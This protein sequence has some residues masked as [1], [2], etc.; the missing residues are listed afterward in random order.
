MIVSPQNM[1]FTQDNI[2]MLL[3]GLPGTGKTTLACSAPDPLIVDIDN[4]VKRVKTEHRKDAIMV[5]TYEELIEDLA[6]PE[7]ANYKTIIIDTCGALIELMKAW[8]E[9]QPNGGKKSGGI[10]QAG[11]GIIKSEFSSLFRKLRQTHNCLLLFHSLKDKDQ[12]GNIIYDIQC[13]GATKQTV[14]Q[15]CDLG[16][17][18]QIINDTRFLCFTPTQTYSAKSTHGIKGMIKVPELTDGMPNDF[19]TSIFAMVKENI[20]KEAES[21]KT[22]KLEYEAAM[23]HGRELVS[24]ISDA[25]TAKE[26]AGMLKNVPEA[27]TSKAELQAMFK[28]KVAEIGLSWNKEKKCYA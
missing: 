15:P 19:L 21:G 25:D 11:Y 26:I 28:A 14:W 22:D 17:Y 2:V 6:R 3:S 23:E 5:S 20:A 13:E 7:I 10:S 27:L 8:A 16:A 24:K 1:D 9:K 18:M 12:E 4:G